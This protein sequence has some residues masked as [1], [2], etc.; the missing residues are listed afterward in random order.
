MPTAT[1]KQ[2]T[3]GDFARAV[4]LTAP[5][6]RYY[7]DEGLIEPHRHRNGRRYY[8]EADINWV[9]FLLHLKGT[10]MSISELKQYVTWRAQGDITIPQRLALLQQV[11]Q[12]FLVQ[13]A[14]VQRHLQI[15]NDKINWYE[16]K[17]A[18]VTDADESFAAYL[19]RLGHQE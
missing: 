9:K 3:I 12:D 7:E 16:E 5:T 19:D 8:E 15:L 17:E 2:Y 11:K 10:G 14:E 13:Y 18:G 1:T 6:L 4:G